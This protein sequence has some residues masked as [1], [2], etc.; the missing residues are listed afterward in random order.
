MLPRKPNPSWHTYNA[1][2][3]PK[4]HGT[5]KKRMRKDCKK[6]ITRIPA[7]RMYLLDRIGCY[8]HEILTIRF[9]RPHSTCQLGWGKF[10][11]DQPLEEELVIGKHWLLG[12]DSVYTGNSLLIGHSTSHSQAFGNLIT[13]MHVCICIYDCTT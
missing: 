7:V 13:C 1:E 11:K 3:I 9:P 10:H 12:G 5:P 6:Q 2:P 8:T 4:A